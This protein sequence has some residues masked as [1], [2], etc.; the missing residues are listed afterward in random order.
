MA[1]AER[2]A[3]RARIEAKRDL[4]LLNF[5]VDASPPNQEVL[6]PVIALLAQ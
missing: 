1:E 6:M 3:C 5:L 4:A 2:A